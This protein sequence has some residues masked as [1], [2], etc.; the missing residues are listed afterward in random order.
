[1]TERRITKNELHRIGLAVYG[2]QWVD[3]FAEEIGIN[4]RTVQRWATGEM[5]IPASLTVPILELVDRYRKVLA[6]LIS[7]VRAR[8]GEEV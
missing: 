8:L 6:D 4:R 1:M 2:A 7:D 5:N 3:P